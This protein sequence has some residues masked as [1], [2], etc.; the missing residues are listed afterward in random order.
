MLEST[1]VAF[2]T[3]FATI[4]PVDVAAMFAALTAESSVAHRRS[5]ALRAS[6]I[7]GGSSAVLLLVAWGVTRIHLTAGLWMGVVVTVLLCGSF[8][9][10]LAKTRKAMPAGALLG[11][12]LLVLVLLLVRPLEVFRER[13]A[14]SI[15]LSCQA[16]M[17]K[18]VIAA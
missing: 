12:S 1:I 6:L 17:I 8:A 3:F 16:K 7:A 9:G 4:G 15:Y 11:I 5:M 18:Y 2:T 13:S 14:T 10:R